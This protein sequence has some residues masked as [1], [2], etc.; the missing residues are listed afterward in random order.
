MSSLVGVQWPLCCF[1]ALPPD[2]PPT[3]TH[4]LTQTP[5]R[6]LLH[7]SND[8]ALRLVG[9]LL[10]CVAA[11]LPRAAPVAAV[12]LLAQLL[13][14]WSLAVSEPTWADCFRGVVEAGGW[15]RGAV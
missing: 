2:P 10:P 6:L 4:T 9:P 12:W 1:A 5:A 8:D 15:G 7:R 14:T 3:H 11:A 13:F